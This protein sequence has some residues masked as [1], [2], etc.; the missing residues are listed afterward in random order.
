ML[1]PV[2]TYHHTA[3]F[4]ILI[5]LGPIIYCGYGGVKGVRIVEIILVTHQW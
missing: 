1:L 5:A 3:L 4:S 2:K